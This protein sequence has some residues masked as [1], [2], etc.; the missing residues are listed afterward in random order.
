MVGFRTIFPII[1]GFRER[2]FH[3]WEVHVTLTGDKFLITK[4]TAH[5]FRQK[6][7]SARPRRENQWYGSATAL[8]HCLGSDVLI[9]QSCLAIDNLRASRSSK[10]S[11]AKIKQA[12]QV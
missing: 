8:Q 12:Q 1:P 3:A 4:V 7:H 2:S 6:S 11:Q 5:P 9:R 10:H